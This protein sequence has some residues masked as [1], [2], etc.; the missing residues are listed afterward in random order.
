MKLNWTELYVLMY[1]TS[2]LNWSYYIKT[3]GCQA[4]FGPNPQRIFCFEKAKRKLTLC[5]NSALFLCFLVVNPACYQ[6][7]LMPCQQTNILG[8]Y[9]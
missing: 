1:I 5:L 4:S 6:Q 8:I 9:C 2:F 3:F 7:N